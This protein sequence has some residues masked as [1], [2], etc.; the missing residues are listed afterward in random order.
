MADKSRVRRIICNKILEYHKE[1]LT[2]HS[3][4][5]I[6][7]DDLFDRAVEYAKLALLAPYFAHSPERDEEAL[8][9]IEEFENFRDGSRC[10]LDWK[11]RL[12]KP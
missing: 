11:E 4:T 9:L 3:E 5:W 12:L 6:P 7:A 1:L 10:I 8:L 2:V